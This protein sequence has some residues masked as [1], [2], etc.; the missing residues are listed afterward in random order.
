MAGVTI[1]RGR[2]LGAQ[3]AG[4]RAAASVSVASGPRRIV[5]SVPRFAARRAAAPGDRTPEL[6]LRLAV[7]LQA[8][9][10][11]TTAWRFLAD[12]DEPDAARIVAAHDAGADLAAAIADAGRRWEPIAA[13]WR[14]A[15]EVGAPLAEALRAV[16]VALRDANDARDDVAVALA[17]PA[18]TSRL[19]SW[20]PLVA[21]AL[22]A[23]MGLNV[24]GALTTTPIGI[25]CL[26]VGLLLMVGAHRWTARLVAAARPGDAV[27]GLTAELVAV[28]LSGGASIERAR[29]LAAEVRRVPEAAESSRPPGGRSRPRGAAAAPLDAGHEPHERG[30][31][32]RILGLSRS[33]GV[34]AVELLRACA[35]MDRQQARTDGRT[36]AARLSSSLLLPLGICVLPAFVVL[37]VAPM[38]M[39][40]LSTTSL[41]R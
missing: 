25:G 6:A 33:A 16:A 37:G 12:A 30:E 7:L 36:R 39:S 34:P 17:E 1:G 29:A 13:A 18:A 35:A 28:A 38:L 23:G 3:R 19:M 21:V 14:V 41:G 40:I 11:P 31:V 9:V 15:T 32:D 22:G 20:L 27:P 24:V 4:R 5:R 26:L 2:R 10:A 8:G